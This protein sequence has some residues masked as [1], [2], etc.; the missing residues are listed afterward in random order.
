VLK[1]VRVR[2]WKQ[3]VRKIDDL[4]AELQAQ[5]EEPLRNRSRY[6]LFRGQ[7]DHRW[8]LKSTLERHDSSVTLLTDY[9]RRAFR[10][11]HHLEAVTGRRQV[12]PEYPDYVKLLP[13]PEDGFGLVDFPAYSYLAYLRHHGF[14]SPLLDWSRSPFVA[15][16]F[17]FRNALPSSKYVALY[18]F[19]EYYRNSKL[20]SPDEA[21]I[22]GVGPYVTTHSRHVLQQCQYTICVQL[23][24]N[25]GGEYEWHYVPHEYVV[26]RDEPLYESQDVFYKFLLPTSLREEVLRSLDAFNLNSHSLFGSEDSLVETATFRHW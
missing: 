11:K 15:A 14:P 3:F 26:G 8:M 4:N 24:R 17:A 20:S 9:Y 7:S 1:T 2:T 16:F 25:P 10:V 12:A 5:V 6:W 19:V 22:V 21:T 18:A 23:K 13:V